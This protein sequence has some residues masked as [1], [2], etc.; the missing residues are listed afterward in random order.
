MIERSGRKIPV[1]VQYFFVSERRGSVRKTGNKRKIVKLN[2]VFA[3]KTFF[4]SG[5]KLNAVPKMKGSSSITAFVTVRLLMRTGHKIEF[6]DA[7]RQPRQQNYILLSFFFP[8]PPHS[9]FSLWASER[10][11]YV[12]HVSGGF[13]RPGNRGLAR[14]GS[15]HAAPG[16]LIRLRGRSGGRSSP[17]IIT[18]T[19][20]K[21]TAAGIISRGKYG[22]KRDLPDFLRC[23]VRF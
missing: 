23:Q 7:C 6:Y 8:E 18:L 9:I 11:R 5:R 15:G 22:S 4:H 16:A 13:P 19:Y 3:L 1:T 20:A 17:R 14:P 2:E 10:K 12:R 21:Q